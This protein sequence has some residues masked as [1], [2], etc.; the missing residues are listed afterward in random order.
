[1][2]KFKVLMLFP[3]LLLFGVVQGQTNVLPEIGA[4]CITNNLDNPE[5]R[6]Y[7]FL[8]FTFNPRIL[9]TQRSNHS[10]SI[11]L[12]FAIRTKSRDERSTRLGILIPAVAMFNFGAGSV[13]TPNQATVGFAAGGGWGYFYQRTR[14]EI[15]ETPQYIES[16]SSHGPIV[17][18]GIRIPHRK[19]TLFRYKDNRAYPVSSIKINYLVNLSGNQKSMGS[20]SWLIGLGF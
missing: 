9:L 11:D 6:L 15:D 8:A 1:M 20:L 16:L 13:S 5:T 3:C 19:Y 18:A 14:S 7:D 10:V 2:R 4:S 17:R 12:P